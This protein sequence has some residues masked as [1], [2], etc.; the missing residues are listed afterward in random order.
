MP[1]EIKESP[2]YIRII[3]SHSRAISVDRRHR[4]IPISFHFIVSYP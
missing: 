4:S 3:L 2:L 1:E